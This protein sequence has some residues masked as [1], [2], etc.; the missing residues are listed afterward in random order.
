MS[1][2]NSGNDQLG[3][4][5]NSP[6]ANPERLDGRISI[7][8]RLRQARELAG[9]SQGQVARL[10]GIHRPT[11]SEIEAG[12]RRVSADELQEM[13][14]LYDISVSWLTEGTTQ[15]DVSQARYQLAA[16]ELAKLKPEDLD[17]LLALLAVLKK[18]GTDGA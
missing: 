13:A 3:S 5:S 6:G 7:A 18:S 4:A 8:T 9:L 1:D 12:R 10:M 14:K 16:R 17:R 15:D 2:Q 11:V